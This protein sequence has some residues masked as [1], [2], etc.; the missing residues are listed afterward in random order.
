MLQQLQVSSILS[1]DAVAKVNLAIAELEQPRWIKRT[2][3]PKTRRV[4]G[5]TCSY[6]FCGHAQMPKDVKDFLKSLA[7]DYKGFS[8]H[9]IAINRYNVGDY[10]GP[11][12]DADL[13][14]KN[15]VIALQAQGDGLL[16]DLEDRFIEDAV[17]Q[18]VL[19]TGVGPI[20]SVPA[21]KNLRHC[22]IY[23]YE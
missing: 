10:I 19:I 7:P 18:G 12:R 3:L 2:V 1:S 5:A 13:Y 21:V 9:E 15:L 22:L 6:E 17:G 11:H 4:N 23:L 14:R 16:I 8:L 20:H